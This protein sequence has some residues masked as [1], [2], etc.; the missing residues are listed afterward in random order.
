[1]TNK[2]QDS[3]RRKITFGFFAFALGMALATLIARAP[4]E[5][6]PE[7]QTLFEYKGKEVTLSDLDS[8][9]ALPLYEEMRESHEKQLELIKSAALQL[10]ISRLASENNLDVDGMT[11]KLFDVEAPTD[12]EIND[13]W[14]ANL[15]RIQRPFNEVQADIK[16]FLFQQK[17]SQQR[18]ALLLQLQQSGD[19]AYSLRLPKSPSVTIDSSGYPFKGNEEAPVQIVEFADYQCPHCKHAHGIVRELA[20]K[21]GNK[22]KVSF[23]DFPVNRS[24]ISRTV[25]EGAVCADAQGKFWEYHDRAFADQSILTKDWPAQTAQ[26]LALDMENFNLCLGAAETRNKVSKSEQAAVAA[27][28]RGTPS[29]FIN[30]IKVTGHDLKEALDRGI[31]AGLAKH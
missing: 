31:Q 9:V 10:H 22:I 3:L 14:K 8:T 21:W 25:A 17:I 1:M 18:E 19:L 20:E 5:P 27:G 11:K 24:G 2:S 29:F 23:M 30:G 28:V 4:S 6:K 13:F 7:T 26:S 12:A 15:E 16:S